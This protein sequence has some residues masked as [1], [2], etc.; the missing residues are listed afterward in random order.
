MK[1]YYRIM[2]G[3]QSKYADE[4]FKGNF[5]G[6]DFDIKQDL[7]K[8][9]PDNWR[10]FNNKFIPVWQALNLGKSKL[11][12]IV[13]IFFVKILQNHFFQTRTKN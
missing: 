5:I 10:D 6:A 12:L 13:E 2:L 1:G 8:D 3:A 9:L 4:C 7:A 11:F